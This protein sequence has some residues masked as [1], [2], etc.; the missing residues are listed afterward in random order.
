MLV[1]FLGCLRLLLQ[2]SLLAFLL[3]EAYSRVPE[4]EEEVKPTITMADYLS[5]KL[6]TPDN[7]CSAWGDAEDEEEEVEEEE[8]EEV[9]KVAN[10][11]DVLEEIYLISDLDDPTLDE[12]GF[13]DEEMFERTDESS[14]VSWRSV[15]SSSTD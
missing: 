1:L 15:L 6:L 5:D 2:V 13:D 11:D 8:K 3:R 10:N 7:N 9:L 14:E 12:D 4:D